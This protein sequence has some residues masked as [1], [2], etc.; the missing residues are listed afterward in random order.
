[1]PYK[2]TEEYS[3]NI[4]KVFLQQN[5]CA[6]RAETTRIADVIIL[7]HSVYEALVVSR[8]WDC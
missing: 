8:L 3:Q 7:A 1:M 4:N 5:V 6:T 2:W